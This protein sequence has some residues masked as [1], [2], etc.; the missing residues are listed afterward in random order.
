MLRPDRRGINVALVGVGNCASSLV[1][2]I[3]HYG[4]GSNADTGLL[5]TDIGGYTAEDI[6]IV[7]A[8]DIDSRKVGRDIAEAIFAL[9]NCTTRFYP[10]VPPTG[11]KVRMGR[12]LDGVAGVNMVEE[13]D[14][15]DHAPAVDVETGDDA[16]GEHKRQ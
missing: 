16:L 10:H 12:L 7:A 6:R 15:L 3:A 4:A 2:G 13:L 1:Q 8:W 14:A 9:P 11:A 5:H